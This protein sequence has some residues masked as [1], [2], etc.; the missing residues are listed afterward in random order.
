LDGAPTTEVAAALAALFPPEVGE[1]VI[2]GD[3]TGIVPG[4]PTAE[5]AALLDRA[6]DVDSRGAALTVRFTAD[7]L[8]RAITAGMTAEELLE[9]LQIGRASG[10]ERVYV[11]VVGVSK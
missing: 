11:S 9:R 6:A 7:S 5:L 8:G 4:R 2:Q 1:L 3:L 10:R